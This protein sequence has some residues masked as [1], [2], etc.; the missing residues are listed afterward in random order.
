MTHADYNVG[1]RL[2]RRLL[3]PA[4]VL[5]RGVAALSVA[6]VVEAVRRVLEV[7]VEVV[8]EVTET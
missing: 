8:V 7:L 1:A 4:W 3:L 5:L 2:R 6:M